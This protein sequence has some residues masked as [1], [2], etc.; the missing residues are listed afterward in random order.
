[1]H[2]KQEKLTAGEGVGGVVHRK[3]E[4]LSLSHQFNPVM[5]FEVF[6]YRLI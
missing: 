3:T 1:V 6:A 5:C 4:N 2:I